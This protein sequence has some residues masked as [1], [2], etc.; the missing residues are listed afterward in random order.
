MDLSIIIVNYNVKYFLEHCLAAVQ[1]ASANLTTQVFVVDN[2]STDESAAYFTNRFPQFQFIYN[3]SNVGFAKANN[4][5]LAKATGKYILFLNPD[6]I[7]PEDC[8]EKCIAFFKATTNCGALGV[9]MIDGAGNFLKE[10]KRS[11]PS[12]L[13]SLYKLS[14]M[15]SLFPHSAKFAKYHLGNLPENKNHE[16][17]VLAGAFIMVQK[18]V[19][20]TVGSFDE[21]F[22]MYGEDVDL[23]YR[24]QKAGYK[25]YYVADT[26]IIHFKGE[27]TKRGSLNYVKMFYKAMSQ[28][29]TKHYGKSKARFFNIFIQLAIF[30]R[31]SLAAVAKG[32]KWLGLP[33]IDSLLILLCIWVTK[34]YWYGFI[35]TEVQ[36]QKEVLWIAATSYTLIYIAVSFFTGLYDK[37]YL[38]RNLNR[39]AVFASLFLIAIYGLVPESYRFSRAIILLSAVLIYFTLSIV[40]NVLAKFNLVESGKAETEEEKQTIVLSNTEDYEAIQKLYTTVQL[41]NRILGNINTVNN[42]G[43]CQYSEMDFFIKNISFTTM[44]LSGSSLNYS[45]I[46]SLVQKYKNQ[47]H[48]KFYNSNCHSIISSESKDAIGET[49]ALYSSFEIVSNTTQR[50]KRL[51]DVVTT[52]TLLLSSPITYWLVKQKNNYFKAIV[53]VLIGNKTFVGYN[54]YN[55]TTLP[56]IQPCVI[57]NC[58]YTYGTATASSTALQYELDYRYAKKYSMQNDVKIILRYYFG[59][60]NIIT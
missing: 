44:V 56:T 37:P 23:S 8:F 57:N 52:L 28:F 26:T 40:K 29:V 54:T 46:I 31:A 3:T 33:L 6:T 15:A 51:V 32:I 53:A 39:S 14:G 18:S 12:P 50:N 22:F 41:P 42:S 43:L 60:P 21:S 1:Q 38:H 34:L 19:L 16:I 10:S 48:T 5:A 59:K 11:F 7:V 4:I 35:K 36:Y 17:D 49:I 24:I 45:T 30:I 25:N 27:S 20:D 58:G 47:C 13:T 55:N 2:N 9:K